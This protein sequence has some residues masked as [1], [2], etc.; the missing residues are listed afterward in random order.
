MG[1]VFSRLPLLPDSPAWHEWRS[2]GIGASDAPALLGENP[3]KSPSRLLREKLGRRDDRQNPSR[4]RG[5]A[6]EPEARALFCRTQHLDLE[7]ACLQSHPFDFMRATVDGISADGLR[8]VEIK[9]GEQAYAKT[10]ATRA[11]PPLYRAQLQHV[12]AITGH[13]EIDFFCYHR[14]RHP[15]HLRVARDEHYIRRLIAA[16]AKF[17]A[18]V[19]HQRQKTNRPSSRH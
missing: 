3:W 18:M 11:P 1:P 14:F 9:C 2:G 13:A 16:E 19:V 7:P 10:A 5:R 17:W 12:L 15:L 4:A 8:V 6:L